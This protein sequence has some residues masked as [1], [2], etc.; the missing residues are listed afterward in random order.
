MQ[1]RYAPAGD[2]CLGLSL[3]GEWNLCRGSVVGVEGI[4]IWEFRG[5]EGMLASLASTWGV[6][7]SIL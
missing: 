6:V 7:R 3:C 5:S 4:I 2:H 1:S